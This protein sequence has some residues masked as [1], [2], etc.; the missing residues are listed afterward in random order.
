MC[1][2]VSWSLCE[3]E[4]KTSFKTSPNILYEGMPPKKKAAP[5]PKASPRATP[6]KKP[7]TESRTPGKKA[8]KT[9]SK[10][11]AKKDGEPAEEALDDDAPADE[12][13]T[14]TDAEGAPLAA[15]AEPPASTPSLAD[16]AAA[17]AAVEPAEPAEEAE[18]ASAAEEPFAAVESGTVEEPASV[19]APAASE[20][21]SAAEEPPAA[22]APSADEGRAE[23][24]GETA[25][26]ETP[27]AAATTLLALVPQLREADRGMRAAK[28]MLLGEDL[29]AVE[30][31]EEE[32]A[33]ALESLPASAITEILPTVATLLDTGSNDFFR[34]TRGTAGMRVHS[35]ARGALARVSDDVTASSSSAEDAVVS[36]VNIM[37]RHVSALTAAGYLALCVHL[38]VPARDGDAAELR[39]LLSL[40]PW[41][42]DE[43]GR[44]GQGYT[45]ALQVACAMGHV[46]CVRI[47]LD[48]GAIFRD[49]DFQPE[50]CR[51][52]VSAP[53]SAPAPRRPARCARR[54]PVSMRAPSHPRAGANAVRVCEHALGRRVRAAAARWALELSAAPRAARG[55]PGDHRAPSCERHILRG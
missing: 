46:E 36:E 41:T 44:D 53:V 15:A 33:R 50:V 30:A 4:A 12:E 28:A 52:P 34:G 6:A 7:A 22:A 13:A 14:T 35:A 55:V 51:A 43:P 42:V 48:C 49:A 45:N 21:A 8:K 2:N 18:A 10:S 19:E 38:W 17:P 3:W 40:D 32:V 9:K 11:G 27:S 16:P 29:A 1:V 54:T 31:L 25:P 47:L 24:Q 5:P 26:S 20:E 37:H 23:L 39:R